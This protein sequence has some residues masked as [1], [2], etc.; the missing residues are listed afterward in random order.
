MM[1]RFFAYAA[2]AMSVMSVPALAEP[3]QDEW[4]HAN[5]GMGQFEGRHSVTNGM[6]AD[7]GCTGISVSLSFMVD[8]MKASKGYGRLAVDGIVVHEGSVTYDSVADQTGMS[9]HATI[10]GHD[11]QKDQ[12][13]KIIDAIAA[14]GELT[15][16]MPDLTRYA[17][18]LKNSADISNCR[19][20][21]AN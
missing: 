18:P 17:V 21:R 19:I 11:W 3:G 20:W 4:V 13:N 1:T 16:D 9:F 14:G 15:L 5:A 10:D 7:Y 2:I 6:T 8:G 12:V